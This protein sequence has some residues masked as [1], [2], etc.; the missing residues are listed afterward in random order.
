M[1]PEDISVRSGRVLPAILRH[2]GLRFAVFEC[3]RESVRD[4]VHEA[5]TERGLHLFGIEK[6]LW[7]VRLRP[8]E[9]EDDLT[10]FH[11]IVVAAGELGRDASGAVHPSRM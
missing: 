3:N 2:E 10:K 1:T 4:I 5:A 8:L 9:Y 6:I 7:T 11:D